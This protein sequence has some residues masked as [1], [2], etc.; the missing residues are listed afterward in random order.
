[1]DPLTIRVARRFLAGL[2]V[3]LGDPGKIPG[4]GPEKGKKPPSG[5]GIAKYVSPYGSTRYV[6][7]AN[8]VAIAALQV[9]SR[10]K[11]HA[12]IANVFTAAEARRSGWASAL[13]AAAR[14]DFK[15]VVFPSEEN[16]SDDGKAWRDKDRG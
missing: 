3:Y 7:Y 8:G 1:M 2:E 11:K 13:L 9:V 12:S 16:L 6:A 15:T 5:N 10:D 4:I 14:R